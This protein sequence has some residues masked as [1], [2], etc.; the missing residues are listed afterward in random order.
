MHI[1]HITPHLPPDQAANALLPV[2]LGRCAV[3]A[4]HEVAYL[5]HPSRFSSGIRD[6]PGP[7]TWIPRRDRRPATWPGKKARSV[8]QALRIA[9]RAAPLV[10]GSDLVHLHSN[11]L[12]IE[13]VSWLARHCG[14]PTVLTIYGTEIWHYERRAPFDPF[15]RAHDDAGRVTYYSERLRQRAAEHGLRQD[16]AHVVHPPVAASFTWANAERRRRARAALGL[17]ARHVLLNVKRLHPFG[18]QRHLIDAMPAIVRAHDVQLLICGAGPLREELAA[19]AQRCGVERHVRFEGLVDNDSLAPYYAAA[20]LF[21]L[22]SV[23]ESLGGVAIE[24]LACGTPVVSTDTAGGIELQELFG[25]DVTLVPREDES[26]LARAVDAFLRGGRRASTATRERIER[27][28]RPAT[29]AR[30]FGEL[31]G[32][33]IDGHG[34]AGR[35]GRT[36]AR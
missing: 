31:Y 15:T 23:L 6:L 7:V 18:G 27:E 9:R 5:S 25:D 10:R 26:A 1:C 4:G 12:L 16:H 30:R 21:V 8:L 32:Q 13:M 17:D 24:A 14:T 20:D 11:G 36:H 22:P 3:D 2:L 34:A 35:A 33:L 29:V 28:L 19:Q